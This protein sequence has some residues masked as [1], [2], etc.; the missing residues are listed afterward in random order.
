[1]TGEQTGFDGDVPRITALPDDAFYISDFI[2]EEE[3]NWLLQKVRA[4]DLFR[5]FGDYPRRRFNK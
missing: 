3:E 1:M 5:I 2:T 4:N